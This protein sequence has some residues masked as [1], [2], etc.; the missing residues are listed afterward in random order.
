M[1]LIKQVTMTMIALVTM[2]MVT[3]CNTMQA[4]NALKAYELFQAQ[5]HEVENLLFEGTNLTW[6]VTGATRI[7]IAT[8]A[9]PRH[10]LPQNPTV[11]QTAIKG[12]VEVAKFAVGGAVLGSAFD[13]TKRNPII[14][15]PAEPIIIEPSFF[16]A[17]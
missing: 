9:A 1:K 14:V 15:P 11:A 7:R 8:A 6:T 16:P 17:P 2:M 12:T 13:A 5:P 10:A 4:E 3:G